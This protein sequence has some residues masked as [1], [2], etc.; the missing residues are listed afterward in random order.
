MYPYRGPSRPSR[1]KPPKIQYIILVVVLLVSASII[2]GYIR[3]DFSYRHGAGLSAA[4]TP[5]PEST[6]T[7]TPTPPPAGGLLAAEATPTPTPEPT[8]TPTP[9][10]RVQRQEF[11][12]LRAHYDNDDI[13]G[14]VWIPNTTLD[15]LVTQGTD[16]SFYL[17]HDIHGRRYVP[18]WIFLD[19]MADIHGHDQNWVIFGHNTRR[20]HKFH[21]VRRFLNEDFFLNNRYIHFSTIYADY[22]FEIFSVYITH[23]RF[24]YIFTN[25]DHHEGGWEY[26]I[27]AFA[28][29]SLFDAGITV[30][31]NDRVLTLSTC[32]MSHR[33]YR[34]PLHARLV[35][36]SFPHLD[37][38]DEE[39]LG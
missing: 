39:Q 1:P 30:S 9:P 6:Q 23:V 27:N 3:S 32:Y 35:S 18:G 21:T 31:G 17:Y 38:P 10:P 7:P 36:E 26:W 24:P 11:L 13:I 33:D 16:N 22:V 4:H 5:A 12:D 15:Y 8:P 34:I 14:R 2:V 19:Y 37:E 25:Y 28:A 20:D 29:K